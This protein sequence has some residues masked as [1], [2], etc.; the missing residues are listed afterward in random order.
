MSVVRIF[1][2][3]NPLAN[4]VGGAEGLTREA[5]IARAEDGV[6][7]LRG[8]IRTY[9]HEMRATIAV[10]ARQSEELVFAESALISQAALDIC[11]VAGSAGME[12]TGEA[13]RGIYAMIDALVTRGVWHTDALKLHVE[14]LSLLNADPPPPTEAVNKI[15]ADLQVMRDFIGVPD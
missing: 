1:Q 15:L 7:T 9:V 5:M 8:S 12:A 6:A 3:S 11:D 14:A 10:L 2:P 13:A 4:M